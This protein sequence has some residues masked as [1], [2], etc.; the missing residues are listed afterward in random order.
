MQFD[1]SVTPSNVHQR[2]IRRSVIALLPAVWLKLV[3]LGAVD[4]RVYKELLERTAMG[5]WVL[6]P[7]G[8]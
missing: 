8:S 2:F 5:Y 1:M 3:K 6:G 7:L 4:H